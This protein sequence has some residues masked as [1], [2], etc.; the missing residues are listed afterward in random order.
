MVLQGPYGPQCWV[1]LQ[2]ELQ[3]LVSLESGWQAEQ[4]EVRPGQFQDHYFLSRHHTVIN[5]IL[6]H[7]GLVFWQ[8]KFSCHSD[9]LGSVMVELSSEQEVA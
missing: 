1:S 9:L 3:F 7:I 5:A 4:A 6:P 8:K 2:K